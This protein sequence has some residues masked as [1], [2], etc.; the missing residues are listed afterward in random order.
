MQPRAT[1][2]ARIFLS[3]SQEML[4]CSTVNMGKPV[5]AVLWKGDLVVTVLV[6]DDSAFIRRS[7]TSILEQDKDICVVAVG[8]NGEEA[9]DL[10]KK[11]DPD[12][13][14]L[15]VEMPRMDGLSALKVIMEEN[16]CPVIMISSL[17][18]EGAV[19][20]LK[21][22]ELGASDFMPKLNA[23]AL[24]DMSKISSELSS[25]IKA[26][27]RRKPF[28]RLL[29]KRKGLQANA[30]QSSPR[31][32][33]AGASGATA[34]PGRDFAAGGYKK[35]MPEIKGRPA[36]DAVAVGVSTGGPPA[37]QK[38]LSAFPE[39]FPVPIIIAQ[40]MPAAFT[41]PFAKRLD[42]LCAISVVE[43]QG[44]EK[45]K[46]GTAYVCP[47]GKHA[48]IENRGA[49]LCVVSDEPKDALYKPSANVLFESLGKALG[50]RG[51]GVTLTGM[52]SD[53][54]EG[55]RVLKQAGG[56]AIAQS[57]PSCVVYGMP[58]AIIDAK[59]ADE[60][61]DLDDMAVAIVSNLYP[62]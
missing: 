51:L 11:H 56:R 41:G 34:V 54:L 39:T 25:K 62:A 23:G 60:I 36:F 24:A 27:A 47:G 32:A 44:T 7:L 22:L 49:L 37:V 2:P 59:L 15:D 5:R 17:T 28:L 21:A 61:V 58:K 35:P 30:A 43:A 26:L 20:T 18:S 50:R 55:T 38:L 53:G 33:G 42:G 3:S 12:V 8:K 14:T 46:P 6:V 57:E 1:L 48:R 40:H 13:V 29:H 4:I 16:P 31:L 9:V 10:V 45:M 52:G 19:T